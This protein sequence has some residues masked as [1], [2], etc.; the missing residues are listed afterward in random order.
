MDT[1]DKGEQTQQ[2]GENPQ[3]AAQNKGRLGK[4]GKVKG[5][6]DGMADSR[7]RYGRGPCRFSRFS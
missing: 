1:K 4:D 2:S 5:P 6:K 3:Q 7:Q